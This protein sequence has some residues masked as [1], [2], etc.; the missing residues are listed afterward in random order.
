MIILILVSNEG[1]SVQVKGPWPESRA[2]EAASEEIRRHLIG[3]ELEPY[4]GYLFEQDPCPSRRKYRL[5][6]AWEG[7]RTTLRPGNLF[8]RA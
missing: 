4:T 3:A 7:N 5:Y 6:A 8:R 2:E 1:K